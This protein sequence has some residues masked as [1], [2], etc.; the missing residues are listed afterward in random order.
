MKS[1]AWFQL[2]ESI[3]LSNLWFQN[4]NL[5]PYTEAEW[6]SNILEERLH[7]AKC[8][9]AQRLRLAASESYK[10]W[11]MSNAAA[12]HAVEAER[13]RYEGERQEFES[14]LV[15]KVGGRDSA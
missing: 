5:H 9:A 15:A 14:Q 3:S 2:F 1:A 13:A 10:S 12:A 4:I 6:V 8:E 11:R 7:Y